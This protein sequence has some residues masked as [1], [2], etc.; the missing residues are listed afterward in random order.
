M[1]QSSRAIHAANRLGLDYTAEAASFTKLPYS[2]I[3]AHSHINGLEAAK[4]YKKA[5]ELYGVSLTYSMTQLEQIPALKEILGEKIR[6]IAMPKLTEEE[7]YGDDI[8]GYIK[9][10]EEF[11]AHGARILKFWSAPRGI[12]IGSKSGRPDLLK[13]NSKRRLSI[14]K[15]VKSLGMVFMVHVG[16]PDTWF[17]TKYSNASIYGTK[18]EQY[19]RFEEVLALVDSPI[20][21]AHMGGW[22]EDLEFL[23]KLLSNHDHLYLDSSATKWMVRELSKHSRGELIDFLKKWQGRILFGSDIVSN[24]SH[25]AL[26]DGKDITQTLKEEKKAE[27]FDLYA[28]RYWALRKLFESTYNAESPIADP[29]LELVAPH[30]YNEMDAPIL[31]GKNLPDDI[32][33]GLYYDAAHKLL[34]PYHKR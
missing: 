1:N 34:E 9:H 7:R 16:D 30:K 32:L 20:I 10:I 21:A 24:D 19:T 3:D 14:M 27:A 17:N 28:S 2:I 6:F 15:E 5:A 33:K 29:D 8:S 13:I 23:S 25:L 4:F 18:S 22:P 11:Y 26:G 12:D 31:V